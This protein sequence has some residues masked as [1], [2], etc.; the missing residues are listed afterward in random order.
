MSLLHLLGLKKKSATIAKD[1]LQIII[2]QGRTDN[3][4]DYLPMLRKEIL[5]VVAKYTNA[6][7]DDV[8][9]DFR[10]QENS[11]VM[12]LN[13]MLP[14]GSRPKAPEDIEA[15]ISGDNTAVETTE[16]EAATV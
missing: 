8:Q 6:N 3:H 4:T 7:L 2:A 13:V 11:S 10:K 12:E 1:R 16:K 15:A 14:E 9:V 5:A